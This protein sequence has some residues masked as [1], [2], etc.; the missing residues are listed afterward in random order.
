MEI[1]YQIKL[2]NLEKHELDMNEQ[3]LLVQIKNRRELEFNRRGSI[4]DEML[5]Y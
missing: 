5:E 4:L 2:N 1:D 3:I